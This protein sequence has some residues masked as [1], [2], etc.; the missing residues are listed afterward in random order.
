MQNVRFR[1]GNQVQEC[2]ILLLKVPIPEPDQ[3]AFL[4]LNLTL[5][6]NFS[7]NFFAYLSLYLSLYLNIRNK[8]LCSNWA[9]SH[10]LPHC[11]SVKS[12]WQFL[13]ASASISK[14]NYNLRKCHSILK[15]EKECLELL[16][17][18]LLKHFM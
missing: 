5:T 10:F 16:S 2:L 18:V 17:F 11:N 1:D 8:K 7:V 15:I 13:T 4:F 14:Q 3:F 12:Y 6:L 9:R